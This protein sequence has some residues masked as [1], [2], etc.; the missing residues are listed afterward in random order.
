MSHRWGLQKPALSGCFLLRLDGCIAW[1]G[2]S[3]RQAF[4]QGQELPDASFELFS[5]RGAQDADS[6]R[7]EV[8]PFETQDQ[9]CELILQ[10]GRCLD[11]FQHCIQRKQLARLAHSICSQACE[12]PGLVQEL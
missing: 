12:C 11:S 2:V 7:Q 9:R 3:V 5:C 10:G 4:H 6:S 8:S 1:G